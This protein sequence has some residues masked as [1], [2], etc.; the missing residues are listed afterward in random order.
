MFR[1]LQTDPETRPISCTMGIGSFP[2]VKRPE[3]GVDHTPP[4]SCE[5]LPPPHLR[6]LKYSY[7]PLAVQRDSKRLTQF[8]TSIFPELYMVCE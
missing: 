8:R 4:P 3:G 1:A 2:G 5:F 6:A 7:L